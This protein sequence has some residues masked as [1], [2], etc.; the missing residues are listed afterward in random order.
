[1]SLK[2]PFKTTEISRMRAR[3]ELID[4]VMKLKKSMS[5]M[6]PGSFP[7]VDAGTLIRGLALTL[8][9]IS[10]SEET[11]K[12]KTEVTTIEKNND[13]DEDANMK[14][15]RNK[16]MEAMR[17]RMMILEDSVKNIA[18]NL[19]GFVDDGTSKP[20]IEP[21]EYSK[22]VQAR[23]DELEKH[24]IEG[25]EAQE[26]LLKQAN[27]SAAEALANANAAAEAARENIKSFREESS[28]K[29]NEEMAAAAFKSAEEAKQA[30]AKVEHQTARE[31]KAHRRKIA[32]DRWFKAFTMIRRALRVK[33]AV[34]MITTKKMQGKSVLER[35]NDVESLSMRN[36]NLISKLSN[37]VYSMEEAMKTLAHNVTGT[38]EKINSL[39]SR[40][41]RSRTNNNHEALI[42]L[43]GALKYSAEVQAR[44]DQSTATTEPEFVV[45]Q[46]DLIAIAFRARGRWHRAYVMIVRANRVRH[47]L[48]GALSRKAAKG[49][50]LLEKLTSLE[51]KVL[52]DE[53]SSHRKLAELEMSLKNL[54]LHMQ[55]F[56]SELSTWKTDFSSSRTPKTPEQLKQWSR[57]A[58]AK[59]MTKSELARY[60]WKKTIRLTI[61]ASRLQNTKGVMSPDFVGKSILERISQLERELSSMLGPIKTAFPPTAENAAYEG[62]TLDDD[63][64]IE[65]MEGGAKDGENE[66]SE[67]AE[68]RIKR[69]RQIQDRL[70]GRIP[71]LFDVQS[72]SELR[73]KKLADQ[74][75][76]Q[77]Q[78]IIGL[79]MEL[80]KLSSLGQN[81]DFATADAL[82]QAL[83]KRDVEIKL[84][85]DMKADK[86]EMLDLIVNKADRDV[87]NPIISKITDLRD[88]FMSFS[89]EQASALEGVVSQMIESYLAQAN[90]PS[91]DAVASKQDLETQL[92]RLTNQITETMDGKADKTAVSI[93]LQGKADRRIMEEKVD[94]DT[95][96]KI[97]HFFQTRMDELS[98]LA[99]S[100]T[101]SEDLALLKKEMEADFKKEMDLH[102]E[103]KGDQDGLATVKCIACGQLPQQIP[104]VVGNYAANKFQLRVRPLD[105]RVAHRLGRDGVKGY[106]QPK[107]NDYI[108]AGGYHMPPNSVSGLRGK[109]SWGAAV[110]QFNMN[111]GNNNGNGAG[112]GG[113]GKGSKKKGNGQNRNGGDKESR[114][115]EQGGYGMNNQHHSGGPGGI[116][117]GRPRSTGGGGGG[118]G[119]T[120]QPTRLMTLDGLAGSVAVGKQPSP[121]PQME[122]DVQ[123]WVDAA[124]KANTASM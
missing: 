95:L 69:T 11:F 87:V 116:G 7:L 43:E 32:R 102:F 24:I 2:G 82:K 62:I 49:E 67:L 19:E 63:G 30:A 21:F 112:A 51:R 71:S 81:G 25:R 22:Q 9:V 56:N 3:D 23:M 100:G 76:R 85:K 122:G 70:S 53:A 121:R 57:P 110:P 60:R 16:E 13:D 1:L 29:I 84:L 6:G 108:V 124:Q 115:N 20:A 31:F 90:L 88:Q 59:E 15:N 58:S 73:S 36:K 92:S 106:T 35:L 98:Q 27:D 99:S 75:E 4:V 28:N 119:N 34:S 33:N 101:S 93:E 72:Q 109:T 39:G 97:Q 46:E 65:N 103:E 86:E 114:F 37:Q 96:N 68:D 42:T 61:M 120:R 5:A 14:A 105:P 111:N 104:T 17:D 47:A 52:Y 10:E 18:Q 94:Q 117:V 41:N 55:G 118:G 77:Q 89:Q 54:A 123:Q 40:L 45:R 64:T 38:D 79:K 78:I 26:A 80:E 107:Q 66:A 12:S 113:V 91:S 8:E 83:I 74:I 50:S 48:S 44:I